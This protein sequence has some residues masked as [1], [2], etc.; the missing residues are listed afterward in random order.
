MTPPIGQQFNQ[1]RPKTQGAMRGSQIVP[2]HKKTVQAKGLS[3][4]FNFDKDPS[5]NE[6]INSAEMLSN[7]NNKMVTQLN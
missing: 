7:E 2:K 1:N 5:S 4:L 6:N 3:F